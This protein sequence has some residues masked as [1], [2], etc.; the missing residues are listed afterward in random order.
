MDI[1]GPVRE[2]GRPLSMASGFFVVWVATSVE[3]FAH[4]KGDTRWRAALSV[5]DRAIE[6]TLWI[7]S[8]SVTSLTDRKAMKVLIDR[9]K[10]TPRVVV[11]YKDVSID[12]TTAL[13]THSK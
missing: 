1:G 7:V 6:R 11:P 9:M 5:L 12:P 3:F 13:N 8:M 2:N 10:G 4:A